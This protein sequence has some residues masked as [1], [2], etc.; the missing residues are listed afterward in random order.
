MDGGAQEAATTGQ[1][2]RNPYA[3]WSTGSSAGVGGGNVWSKE[4]PADGSWD[5]G[6]T[7]GHHGDRSNSWGANQIR[8]QDNAS[9]QAYDFSFSPTNDQGQPTNAFRGTELHTPADMKVLEIQRSYSGSGGYG[10]FIHLEDVET[11]KRI[12]VN[13]LDSVG[14]FRIGDVIPGGTVFGEQGGSGNARDSYAVH[15]DIIGTSGAVE[16]FVRSQ[17]SGTFRSAGERQQRGANS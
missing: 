15:V 8:N 16:D 6:D 1:L 12:V 5:M 14:E 2:D 17:Q 11:G 7:L 3:V 13:H 9:L 4:L 10:C